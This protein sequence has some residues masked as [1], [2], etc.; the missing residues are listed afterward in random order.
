MR[1]HTFFTRSL[2][3]SEAARSSSDDEWIAPAKYRVPGA[4][5]SEQ[6]IFSFHW[7][8]LSLSA[9]NSRPYSYSEACFSAFVLLTGLM[10]TSVL[11]GSA[12]SML[13]ALD[14]QAEERVTY[15]NGLN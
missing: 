7:A 1:P 4:F 10:T 6:Y 2:S 11:V 5:I 13:L 15:K 8:L 9:D 12:S 3:A 14:T